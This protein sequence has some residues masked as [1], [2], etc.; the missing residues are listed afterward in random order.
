MR[1]S[2]NPSNC[3][4][5]V[6]N[7]F[8]AGS[9]KCRDCGFEWHQHEGVIDRAIADKFR[10][11]WSHQASGH[12]SGPP[13]ALSSR[14]AKDE[15]RRLLLQA[16]RGNRGE[17]PRD[18]WLG[19]ETPGS[20]RSVR[21]GDLSD[22]DEFKFYSKE[23]FLAKEGR[24]RTFSGSAAKPVKVVN[25]LN[26]AADDNSPKES[27][28]MS[29]TAASSP[30]TLPSL[31]LPPSGIHLAQ[32]EREFNALR[33]EIREKAEVIE[34]LERE[35]KE[36]DSVE[37][38]GLQ[39]KLRNLNEELQTQRETSEAENL[40]ETLTQLSADHE[41]MMNEKD[42]RIETLSG[43]IE[44]L[45]LQLESSAS[46][47]V[48][49]TRLMGDLE[50]AAADSTSMLDE[51]DRVMKSSNETVYELQQKLVAAE[52]EVKETRLEHE[53]QMEVMREGQRRLVEGMREEQSRMDE[54]RAQTEVQDFESEK[55]L[56]EISRLK[57]E[58]ESTV[59][60]NRTMRESISTGNAF[61]DSIQAEK[62]QL[63]EQYGREKQD[64]ETQLV[65][66]NHQVGELQN[67]LEIQQ[68]T[69]IE[70][71]TRIASLQEELNNTSG[72][73]SR[74]QIELEFT[75]TKLEESIARLA[76]ERETVSST[77]SLLAR[78]ESQNEELKSKL[79]KL[80]T[81]LNSVA[82]QNHSVNHI[83]EENH[84]Y[85]QTINDVTYL[86]TSACAK[87]LTPLV[88][89][90]D[91]V[92]VS[93]V[94]A[95]KALESSVRAVMRLVDNVTERSDLLDKENA[96]LE[97]HV[98]EIEIINESLRDRLNKPLLQRFFEPLVGCTWSQNNDTSPGRFTVRQNKEMSHLLPP[99]QSHMHDDL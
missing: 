62:Q 46:L 97:H 25:L 79:S 57:S 11:I 8:K 34:K 30:A 33:N 35:L 63:I 67:Q 18:E 54:I 49:N 19:G 15:K 93:G 23:E 40:S 86:L 1:M 78:A 77:K 75:K 82:K 96:K 83:S 14:E 71:E 61:V 27:A 2:Q 52:T 37:I 72:S 3:G 76:T 26:Y 20:G 10:A 24:T 32:I 55:F 68:Q 13:T 21:G 91:G 5:F 7:V 58:L 69:I 81:E 12:N 87:Y 6:V 29:T 22:E 16:A 99:S 53:R 70:N 41:R 17:S 90:N 28:S 39:E 89:E 48:E 42:S 98:Y 44:S 92:A 73:S 74:T 65:S 45:K 80:M 60:E 51:L 66:Q 59:S 64:F 56:R 47:S 38:W 95:I 36:K 50:R 9:G 4:K 88:S 31:P 43:E 84:M 94:H 85:L